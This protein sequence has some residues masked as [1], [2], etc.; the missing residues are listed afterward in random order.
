MIQRILVPVA[1]RVDAGQPAIARAVALAERAGAAVRLLGVAYDPHLEGYLGR[2]EIYASLRERVVAERN[3]GVQ[4]LARDLSARGIRCDAKALWGRPH[5]AVARE[6]AEPEVDLV[7][8]QPED[9]RGLSNDEWRLVSV[10]PAPVLVVRDAAVRPYARVVAAVDPV[11][12][13][14]KPADLDTR[15]LDLARRMQELSGARLEVVHCLPPLRSFATEDGAALGEAERTIRAELVRELDELL[16]QAG[17]PKAAAALIDGK[18]ADVLVE[19]SSSPEPTLLVLGTVQRGP[20]AR[21]VVG[22]TAERVLRA[23][24]GDVLV[25]RPSFMDETAEAGGDD[26][27]SRHVERDPSEFR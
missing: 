2:T 1:E 6:A 15:I 17:V 19:R 11:R 27:A 7:V 16:D 3:A 10:C 18:P 9:V 12:A 4:A 22:S 24:G 13:H 26:S 25:I 5:L 8:F 21:I 20:I 23:D 14:D